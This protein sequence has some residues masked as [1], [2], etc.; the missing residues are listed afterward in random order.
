MDKV[1]PQDDEILPTLAAAYDALGVPAR[2]VTILDGMITRALAANDRLAAVRA[3]VVRARSLGHLGESQ[4]ALEELDAVITST[5]EMPY[6]Y[7]EA[8]ALFERGVLV[9]DAANIE[10]GE[11]S[12]REALAIFQRLGARPD[13]EKTEALLASMRPSPA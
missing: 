2:A 9:L 8:R 10:N 5:R 13:C 12:L 11:R 4:R 3:R 6:P 1:G 7:M